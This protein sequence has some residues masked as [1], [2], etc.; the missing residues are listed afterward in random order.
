[1]K[2]LLLAAVLLSLGCAAFV[3]P[4]PTKTMV[5]MPLGDS[6]TY[7]VDGNADTALTNNGGYRYPLWRGLMRMGTTAD[8]VGSQSTGPTTT[9]LVQ[10]KSLFPRANE[11]HPGFRI[12]QI[13]AQVAGW[14]TTYQPH[15]IL[16]HIGTNDI[17]QNY[18]VASAP[19]RLSGL[20]DQIATA[21]PGA[22]I[23][24][25]QLIPLANTA[26]DQE[27]QAYNAAIPGIVQQ[28]VN[29]GE[30]VQYVDMHS[31]VAA[32]L[33]PDGVHPSDTGYALMASVWLKALTEGC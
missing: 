1:M 3:S 29:L 31:A 5:I 14:L 4:L 28:K 20:L 18:A 24:V 13:S 21:D 32:S 23:I 16:L 12:D 15:V 10:N 33:L 6:I 19:S 26:L 9:P 27:V 22:T 8:F 11:G 2:K 25:A 17:L 30:H 7:G